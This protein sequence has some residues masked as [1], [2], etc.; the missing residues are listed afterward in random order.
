MSAKSLVLSQKALIERHQT[1][2]GKVF[3]TCG[4]VLGYISPAADAAMQAD[5]SIEDFQYAECRKEGESDWVPCLMVAGGAP[6]TH[7]L[8]EGLL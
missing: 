1:R 2:T 3:F 8:G 4:D 7:T 5:K 6:V